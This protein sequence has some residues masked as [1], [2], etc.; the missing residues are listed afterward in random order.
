MKKLTTIGFIE[1]ANSVHKNRYDYCGTKYITAHDYVNIM[2]VTHGNFQQNTE[3]KNLS[4]IL[5][6][7]IITS[8]N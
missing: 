2:C 8:N 1:K 6:N 3:R 5:K 7:N 4:T